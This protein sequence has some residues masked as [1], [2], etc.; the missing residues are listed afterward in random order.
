M[1]DTETA[2]APS[3]GSAKTTRPTPEQHRHLLV[4]HMT[5]LRG[6]R[7]EIEALRAPLKD[8]QEEFTALMNEAKADLGKGYTRKY[9]TT[10]LEDST[11]RLRD[12]LAEEERRARDRE[13]LGLPV[14]GVQ[15]DLFGAA[16]A[17]MPEE[18]RDEIHWE[19]EG[20]MRGRNGMLQ[21]IPEG[22]PPRFHPTILKGYSRGQQ[23]TQ[24]DFLAGQEL[25]KKQANP[26]ATAAAQPLNDPEPTIAEARAAERKSV[27]KAKESLKTIGGGASEDRFEASET[28]IAAQSTRKAVQGAREGSTAGQKA[29]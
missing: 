16:T 4:H 19:A 26:D 6:K 28:E 11:T 15:A 2:A 10:L 7:S 12:L 14:F 3:A 9:L 27:A 5:K 25:K 22:A 23:A 13:A 20:Y 24:E 17:K 21:Q 8:A 18:A 29:A 1:A